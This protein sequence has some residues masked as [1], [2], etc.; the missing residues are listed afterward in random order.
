MEDPRL[1]RWTT[2]DLNKHAAQAV[3]QLRPQTR[4]FLRKP[5]DS[6]VSDACKGTPS[7]DDFLHVQTIVSEKVRSEHKVRITETLA[8]FA[9]LLFGLFI[10][11]ALLA[12]AQHFGPDGII[13]NISALAFL[14]LI[15]LAIG[16]PTWARPHCRKAIRLVLDI[17]PALIQKFR[18]SGI[19][20]KMPET[21]KKTD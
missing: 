3:E 15:G 13:Y 17:A 16:P 8:G 10:L 2:A 6:E 18:R 7:E 19:T 5:T 1:T 20:I 4:S 21:D 11:V 9:K 12:T 14:T